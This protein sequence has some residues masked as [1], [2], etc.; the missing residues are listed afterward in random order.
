M[1]NSECGIEGGGR[2]VTGNSP[3]HSAFR[4]PHSA[5]GWC[6]GGD[7]GGGGLWWGRG[8]IPLSCWGVESAPRS[9]PPPLPYRR[10]LEGRG[11]RRRLRRRVELRAARRDRAVA[12]EEGLRGA[13]R[14]V[15]G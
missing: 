1:R 13:R 15:A 3:C 7:A 14:L 2:A 4:I 11:D 5:L 9:R 8:E 10:H 6:G 12:P